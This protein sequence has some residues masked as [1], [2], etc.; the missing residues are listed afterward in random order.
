VGPTTTGASSFPTIT[1]VSLRQICR[2]FFL[3][4]NF[5]C[6]LFQSR[7]IKKKEGWGGGEPIGF[8]QFEFKLELA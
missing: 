1:V 7:L 2:V 6:I 5:K 8:S 4:I 3:K